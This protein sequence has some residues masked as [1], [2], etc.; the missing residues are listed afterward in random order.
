MSIKYVKTAVVA[1]TIGA[2]L[3]MGLRDLVC[4]PVTVA[5]AQIPQVSNPASATWIQG[6]DESKF[7]LIERQL[8]GFDITMM[9]VGYRYD[10]L[11]S[12]VESRNVEY[13][14]YQAEKIAHTIRLGIERR[15][16]RA[17]SANPFL[18]IAVPQMLT[19]INTGQLDELN[20]ALHAFHN[21]CIQCHRS[22]NVLFMG[23][24]FA[25]I[26]PT[27][28]QNREAVAKYKR[29]VESESA[30]DMS[31]G[32]KLF[33]QQ[34]SNCHALFSEGSKTGPDLE[35]LQRSSI[36]YL[37]K[38]IIDPNGIVGFDYQT[39]QVLTS[40]GKVFSGVVK[41]ENE[42]VLT[43]Q[44]A[45]EIVAVPKGEI[46]ERKASS[47]SIMPEGLLQKLN[48][49][50]VRDLIAYLQSSVQ[51]PLNSAAESNK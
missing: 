2:V 35:P 19:A 44:T 48:D 17:S 23:N 7:G 4:E 45:E 50:E 11:K 25:T 9:E 14:R 30:A 46:E 27:P 22:E 5:I 18:E 15:P 8:R 34:C 49:A 43:L 39:Q 32:R 20:R 12:A 31:R 42:S 13:A 6:S 38:A 33:V 16:K 37:L 51:V 28:P 1:L 41:E 10:E 21:G 24:R 40:D 3:G 26:R 36:D 29:L 47:V